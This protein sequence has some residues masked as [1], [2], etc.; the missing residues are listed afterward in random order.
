MARCV[1]AFD[2]TDDVSAPGAVHRRIDL[3]SRRV[4]FDLEK[5]VPNGDRLSGEYTEP[6]PQTTYE[7]WYQ[8]NC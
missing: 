6:E 2:L 5:E 7:R 3:S 1:L 8:T 4:L